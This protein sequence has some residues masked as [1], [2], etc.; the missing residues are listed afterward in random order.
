MRWH[1]QYNA[2]E[3]FRLRETGTLLDAGEGYH[4][5]IERM[6]DKLGETHPLITDAMQIAE[7][8]PQTTQS[9][10]PQRP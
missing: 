5:L 9:P 7:R 10:Q 2:G 1:V 4:T 8:E 3:M 6:Y